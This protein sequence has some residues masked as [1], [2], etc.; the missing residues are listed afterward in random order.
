MHLQVLVIVIIQIHEVESHFSCEKR[1]FKKVIQF[2]YGYFLIVCFTAILS[3]EVQPRSVLPL[4]LLH[5]GMDLSKKQALDEMVVRPHQCD[6]D[7][8]LEVS[9]HL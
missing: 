4:R 6:G 3:V 5:A 7:S 8:S 1:M 2:P 9:T